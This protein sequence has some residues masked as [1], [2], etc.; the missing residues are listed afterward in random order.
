MPL[1]HSGSVPV[2]FRTTGTIGPGPTIV[3][4]HGFLLDET[5]FDG[6]REIL[7]AHGVTVVTWDA[8]GH[9][10]TGYGD[11]APFDYWDLARD[12]LAVLDAIGLERAVFGGVSQGGYSA[13]RAALLAPDRVSGLALLDTEAGACT[14]A[15]VAWYSDFFDNWWGAADPAPSAAALAPQLIG[16]DPSY[17]PR[18][19]EKWRTGD[20][21][22]LRPA[23]AALVGRDDVIDRLP[24][25]RVPALV[26]RG[27][28]D[29]SSTAEKCAVLAAGLGGP[30]ESVT[31]AGAG[32]G[33]ALTDP[34]PVAGALLRLI[35]ASAGHS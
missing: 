33:C 28:F 24:E 10:R 15:D 16:G 18:W 11:G 12:A 17:W 31:V 23:A 5:M 1:A 7:E 19:Q 26:A 32:H 6:L 4:G 30:V 21:A 9:G 20:R 29:G 2:H 22:G 34:A 35:A 27:E 13:L 14:A 25:I 3:L 8:R